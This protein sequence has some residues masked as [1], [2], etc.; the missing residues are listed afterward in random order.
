MQSLLQSGVSLG[1]ISASSL[2]KIADLLYTDNL[3]VL[4]T[5]AAMTRLARI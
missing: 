5:L 1:H 4:V 3:V 2:I